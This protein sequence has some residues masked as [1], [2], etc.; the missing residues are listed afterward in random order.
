MNYRKKENSRLTNQLL[1]YRYFKEK[2]INEDVKFTMDADKE[3]IKIIDGKPEELSPEEQKE[4]E[5]LNKTTDDVK[6]LAAVDKL[7]TFFGKK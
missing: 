4:V 3:I 1:E 5:K 2:Y 7:N 6:I